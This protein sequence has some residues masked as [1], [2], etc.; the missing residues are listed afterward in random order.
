MTSPEARVL[1][2]LAKTLRAVKY[3]DPSLPKQYRDGV[4]DGLEI[5][6]RMAQE[7][8]DEWPSAAS[9]ET[10]ATDA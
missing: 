6:A 7:I 1:R 5:A 2:R 9:Q 3:D 8:A 4:R 10:A